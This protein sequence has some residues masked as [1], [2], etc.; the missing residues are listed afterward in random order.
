[1]NIIQKN[2]TAY[3]LTVGSVNVG[4]V[5]LNGSALAKNGMSYK[6]ASSGAE[7][8]LAISMKAGRMLKGTAKA[9]SLAGTAHSDVFWGGKGNDAIAGKNG[10]DVAVYDKTA[11]GK[12]KILKTDGTM[13][14][15]FKDLRKADVVQKLNGTTMTLSRKDA[16]GQSI[17]VQGWSKDTHNVVF[18][19][20]MNAFD[21][22]LKASTSMA[23]QK[24]APAARNEVWKK[25]GLAQA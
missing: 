21:K 18:G 2:N 13:T 19:G 6:L 9:N 25:A 4:T 15:L 22:W 11:W 1:M 17:T 12:D 8:N 7:I 3:S 5:K 24:A 16:K 23:V 14:I 10:R 20:T